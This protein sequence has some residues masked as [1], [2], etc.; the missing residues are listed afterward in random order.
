MDSAAIRRGLIA[1]LIAATAAGCKGASDPVRDGVAAVAV[2]PRSATV[3]VGQTLPL[4]VTVTSARGAILKDREIHW[5]VDNEAVVSISHAGLVTAIAPGGATVA[6]S[7]EGRSGVATVTVVLRAVAAVRVAPAAAQ[8]VEGGSTQL[9]AT[10]TDA[11]GNVLTGREV[12]WVSA[13]NTVATV[14]PAGLVTGVASGTVSILAA[15]EGKVG[16]ATVTV[17]PPP[18]AKIVANP[19]GLSIRNG[20]SAPITV[21]LQDAAGKTL[22]G[23]AI[24]WST[25]DD[26][27][28]SVIATATPASVL[29]R[30]NAPGVATITVQSEGV[31]LAVTVI[32]RII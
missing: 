19:T 14:T 24:T 15:S 30:G 2:S 29:V 12:G 4:E 22:T 31:T 25:S 18:V 26:R 1:V 23:R 17:I 10:L 11:D 16:T 28:A 20:T 21:T 8:V 3:L 13:N 27:I 5:R 6:A 9:S 7:A 32:V